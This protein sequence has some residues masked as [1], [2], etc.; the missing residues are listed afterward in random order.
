MMIGSSKPHANE[1]I[2]IKALKNTVMARFWFL[3]GEK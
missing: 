3:N 2:S 1:A